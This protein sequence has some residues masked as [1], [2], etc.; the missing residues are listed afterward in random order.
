MEFN[1]P[2]SSPSRALSIKEQAE[3]LHDIFYRF[4]LTSNEHQLPKFPS[5]FRHEMRE[6]TKIL[7][8]MVSLLE[9]CYK[10]KEAVNKA[11]HFKDQDFV[12]LNS[13]TRLIHRPDLIKKIIQHNISAL[14]EDIRDFDLQ[15]NTFK[16][17]KGKTK[18]ITRLSWVLP[19]GN[20]EREKA[21][22]GESITPTTLYVT[23]NP[24]EILLQGVNSSWSSCNNLFHSHWGE[25][26]SHALSETAFVAFVTSDKYAGE[27]F[28]PKKTGRVWMYYEELEKAK[29][30]ILAGGGAYQCGD[31]T[32][33]YS[34]AAFRQNTVLEV[35]KHLKPPKD[36]YPT[37][38]DVKSGSPGFFDICHSSNTRRLILASI[39]YKQT[40]KHWLSV[41][42]GVGDKVPCI[43]CGNL[44]KEHQG[45]CPE[46]LRP[47][48]KV[49]CDICDKEIPK[50]QGKEAN[51]LYFCSECF[52]KQFYTCEL[53]GNSHNK[54]KKIDLY[55][56]KDGKHRT[57]QI[58]HGCTNTIA[59]TKCSKCG[60][61]LHILYPFHEDKEG[62]ILCIEC[63]DAS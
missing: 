28:I 36:L 40:V 60:K 23:T 18:K 41:S 21:K 2:I 37:L 22:Y 25:C 24:L 4:I 6:K 61:Y 52:E 59:I 10:A 32:D 7:G 19:E 9:K 8:S 11:L 26:V 12:I 62:K 34:T 30:I 14:N 48:S 27:V 55:I 39:N 49:Y 54:D 17:S 47:N 42:K 33:S 46:H 57:L 1:C 13:F 43:F 15:Q 29:R 63:H 38:L 56:Y 31:H 20:F 44:V 5:N 16:T 50:N 45:I 58:C 35:L 3:F 51:N 53:C